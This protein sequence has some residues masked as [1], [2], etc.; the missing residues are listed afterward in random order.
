MDLNQIKSRLQQINSA[1]NNGGKD[2]AKN[3]WKPA[4]GKS[5][6]RVVPS[7]YDKDNPFT[8]LQFHTVLSKYPILALTNFGKKDPV[9]EFRQ[10]LQTAGGKENWSLSGKLTPRTYYYVPV[11]VRGEE[12]KG[13]R[14]WNIGIT[15]YKA[16]LAL[17]ADEDV[18]DYTDIAEGRDIKIT[19]VEGNP[20]PDTSIMPAMKSTPLSTDAKQVEEWL[21][22]QPEPIRCFREQTY[23]QIK[24]QLEAFV[25]GKPAGQPAPKP[26]TAAAEAEA[27]VKEEAETKAEEAPKLKP[28]PKAKTPARSV[29]QK[30]N[31]LFEDEG[32]T[33]ESKVEV[34]PEDDL[35]F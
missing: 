30:F 20:Y 27:E 16:L 5:T 7:A 23:D 6:V 8:E 11:I 31:D 17:A 35:P 4:I 22:N 25:Q 10:A 33:E 9:E 15:L 29:T 12:D 24:T 26:T 1:Q 19:K 3:F 32:D 28:A 13:V 18:G 21:K 2:F 14:L 34:E